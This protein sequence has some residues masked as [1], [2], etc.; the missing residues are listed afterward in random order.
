MGLCWIGVAR[1]RASGEVR[2]GLGPPTCPSGQHHSGTFP[3]CWRR[4]KPTGHRGWAVG[5]AWLQPKGSL[6][7]LSTQLLG[8]MGASGRAKCTSPTAMEAPDWEDVR[9]GTV[10]ARNK[11]I[12]KLVPSTHPGACRGPWPRGS[13]SPCSSLAHISGPLLTLPVGGGSNWEEDMSVKREDACG[14]K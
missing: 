8:E 3:H 7:L 9:R 11:S 12:H 13:W 6:G 5:R 14:L 10:K 1:G 4:R 2:A